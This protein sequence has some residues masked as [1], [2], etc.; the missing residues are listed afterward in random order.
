MHRRDRKLVKFV[1]HFALLMLLGFRAFAYSWVNCGPDGGVGTVIVDPTDSEHLVYRAKQSRQTYE[2]EDGGTTWH[3]LGQQ[4]EADEYI[5]DIETARYPT[6]DM[7]VQKGEY[8]ATLTTCYRQS[9]DGGRTWNSGFAFPEEVY[10]RVIKARSTQSKVLYVLGE[11]YLCFSIL[12]ST[13]GGAHWSS[14]GSV[15]E[16][17]ARGTV[18]DMAIRPGKPDT[19]FVC[20]TLVDSNSQSLD[21]LIRSDDGGTNWADVSRNLPAVTPELWFAG[22]TSMALSSSDTNRIYT[23]RMDVGGGAPVFSI[24]RRRTDLGPDQPTASRNSACRDRSI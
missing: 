6:I 24:G 17:F 18:Q 4:L 1:L 20:G 3:S 10:G 14:L 16:D 7:L 22:L 23:A 13:D 5:I 15:T 21:M 12:K 19:L 2:T 11:G 8:P 9:T